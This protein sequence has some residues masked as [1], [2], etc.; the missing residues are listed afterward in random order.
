MFGRKKLK[1]KMLNMIKV[2][3]SNANVDARIRINVSEHLFAD[4]TLFVIK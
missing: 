1:E 4:S 2:K 3:Y